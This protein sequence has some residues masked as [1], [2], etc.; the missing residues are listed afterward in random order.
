MSAPL[1]R[2]TAAM[3]LAIIGGLFILLSGIWLA[4]VG[5]ILSLLTSGLGGGVLILLGAFGAVL[6][7]LILVLGVLVYIQPQHHVVFGALILLLS[8]I[9]LTSLG[10]FILG[11]ILALIAGILALVWKPN[12]ARA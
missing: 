12:T 4:E 5:S 7:V 9:S 1:P 6:G 11:F 3:V 10:G 8:I 2:P